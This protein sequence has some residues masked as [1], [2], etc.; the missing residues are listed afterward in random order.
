M[1]QRVK[2]WTRWNGGALSVAMD[3]EGTVGDALN[4]LQFPSNVEGADQ[5]E[6][7]VALNFDDPQS[8]GWPFRGVGNAGWCWLIEVNTSAQEGY[9]VNIWWARNDGDI[10]FADDQP[11]LGLHLYPDSGN[12]Q[13]TDHSYEVAGEGGD[14]RTTLAATEH[15]AEHDVWLV[16]GLRWI[17]STK[18][19][20]GYIKL[21]SVAN[22]DI[23]ETIELTGYGNGLDTSGGKTYGV[24]IGD[25]PWY[26]IYQHERMS[27][28]LGRIKIFSADIGQSD[29]VLESQDM[30]QLV[31][32]A[33]QAAI[34]Y[35]KNNW[36]SVDDLTC[37]Y[38]TGRAFAWV[39]SGNKA[40]LVAR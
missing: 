19:A 21:P 12:N 14:F 29:L 30:S 27:A 34:W 2:P 25:S 36:D 37:D 6:P 5:S 26:S 28:K 15:A 7:L 3:G 1:V 11:Y 40:T 33:G 16:Q 31:T 23:I 10:G 17:D 9:Y 18:K 13:G 22:A 4:A 39:D 20:R 38:G 32:V 8:N 35:G 24:T